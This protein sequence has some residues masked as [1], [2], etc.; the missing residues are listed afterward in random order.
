MRTATRCTT[1]FSIRGA[2][3]RLRVR[4][5]AP[6]TLLVLMALAGWHE[7]SLAPAFGDITVFQQLPLQNDP[8]TGAPF[9]GHDQFSTIYPFSGVTSA[10][11]LDD[12]ELSTS[13]RLTSITWWGAPL[14]PQSADH[15]HAFGVT[16]YD[17]VPA[18]G[19][20]PSHPGNIAASAEFAAPG[21]SNF[22]TP[23][24]TSTQV[25]DPGSPEGQLIEYSGSLPSGFQLQPSTVYWLS[26]YSFADA[27]EQGL[28]WGWHTRDYTIP[29]P[30]S[31]GDALVGTVGGLPVNQFGSSALSQGY[32]GNP[33][34]GFPVAQGSPIALSYTA[35]A[36]GAAGINAFGM[37]MAFALYT[38]P[39][40]STIVLSAMGGLALLACRW[41]NI[42]DA[43]HRPTAE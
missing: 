32:F 6:S 43:K 19:N 40:P 2:A 4:R 18:S 9:P 30:L 23:L 7:C 35:G 1:L 42:T 12:F 29:N 26:I 21:F 15:P 41:R 11:V 8:P 25:S 33:P 17:N 38:A 13:R 36:D 31:S 10:A 34:S 27:T 3:S 22:G 39:E 24:Y 16:V 20:V 28:S 37:D 14:Q 5:R